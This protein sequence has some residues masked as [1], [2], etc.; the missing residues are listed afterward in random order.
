VYGGKGAAAKMTVFSGQT[1]EGAQAEAWEDVQRVFAPF[2][3]ADEYLLTV[4]M[5][6]AGVPW[7]LKHLIDTITQPGL[8]FGF[9]PSEGYSP[10]L[11]NKRA[12]VIYTSGVYSPG[13]P[14]QF[15]ADFHAKFFN[16][17]LRFIGV[18][19]VSEIRFQPTVLTADP[20]G[21]RDAALA[22]A[23]ELASE[24]AAPTMRAA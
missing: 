16:D 9:D 20:N 14:I 7:V 24:L 15:G 4:P 6:N 18:D 2:K 12:V 22:R 10:L 5:W 23:R 21:A 17:W 13:A 11:E 19:D 8:V 3:D 1:P